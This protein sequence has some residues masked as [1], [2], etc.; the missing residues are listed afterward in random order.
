[1]TSSYKTAELAV[2]SPICLPV[3]QEDQRV[4][5]VRHPGCTGYLATD[6][7]TTET[8]KTVSLL[9]G[10]GASPSFG[11]SN[12][13]DGRWPH[14]VYSGHRTPRPLVRGARATARPRFKGPHICSRRHDAPSDL[15]ST[16]ARNAGVGSA[17]AF[18]TTPT[19]RPMDVDGEVRHTRESGESRW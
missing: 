12:R 3:T 10:Q 6:L 11:D 13:L 14:P 15:L 1:M 16:S 8:W 9:E 17:K 5:P 19:P 2:R 7:Q 18:L 4:Q